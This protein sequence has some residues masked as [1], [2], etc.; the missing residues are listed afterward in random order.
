MIYKRKLIKAA[1]I[2]DI[3]VNWMWN[4]YIAYGK[5]TLLHGEQGIGKTLLSM[6]LLAAC[7]N[8]K[9]LS[10]DSDRIEPAHALYLTDEENLEGIIR[11]KLVEAD[12]DLNKVFVVNED[13]AITLGDTWLEEA[14][15]LNDIR[16]LIIDPIDSYL[17][18]ENCL[19]HS[20]ERAYPIIRK[21]AE[22]AERT[23]CAIVLVTESPGLMSH[24]ARV[25][26]MVF[27][28]EIVSYLCLVND[29]EDEFEERTLYHEKSLISMEGFPVDYVIRPHK[30][31]ELNI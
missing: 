3:K 26:Q 31:L 17:D 29:E 9:K 19:D 28:S 30:G 4:P 20:P 1:D 7:T 25:W 24:Q 8:R 11:P 23:E 12:A 5:V 18:K 14:I 2:E 10:D 22:I 16:L 6:K 27:E 15:V 13:F 21:L